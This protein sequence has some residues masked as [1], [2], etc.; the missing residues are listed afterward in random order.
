MRFWSEHGLDG[1]YGGMFGALDRAGHVNA[2]LPTAKVCVDRL[3]GCHPAQ[4]QPDLLKLGAAECNSSS[5]LSI[6]RGLWA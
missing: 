4:I 2:S 1:Q 3:W 5:L 6:H